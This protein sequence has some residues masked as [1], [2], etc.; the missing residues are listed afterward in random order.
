MFTPPRRRWHKP[1]PA[2]D[3]GGEIHL[4]PEAFARMKERLARVKASIPALAEDTAQAAALGDRSDNAAYKEAKSRL[5]RANGQALMLEDQLKRVTIIGGDKNGT[6]PAEVRLG[7]MVT[8][9]P[10]GTA[11]G[12]TQTYRILGPYESDPGAG[13]ISFRSPLGAALMGHK[14]SDIIKIE[15]ANGNREYRITEIS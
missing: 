9:E 11:G 5:R 7:S 1:Q 15:T 10:A 2:I 12:K 4:T 3:D 8:I 6:V 14:K 13:K